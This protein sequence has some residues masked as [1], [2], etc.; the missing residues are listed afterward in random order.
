MPVH[1]GSDARF[2]PFSIGRR[3]CPGVRLATTVEMA[4]L[5]AVVR[6]FDVQRPAKG[7]LDNTPS[8]KMVAGPLVP[9]RVVFAPAPQL[10][11]TNA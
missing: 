3:M 11:N 6:R 7:K 9:T 5:S 1:A 2:C 8:T 4:F 10:G